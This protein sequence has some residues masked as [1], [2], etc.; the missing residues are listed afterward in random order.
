LCCYIIQEA[1]LDQVLPIL[2][3]TYGDECLPVHSLTSHI[4]V[5]V[6]K[7]NIEGGFD[8]LEGPFE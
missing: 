5:L 7:M 4:R 3:R 1:R 2:V 8:E 6:S